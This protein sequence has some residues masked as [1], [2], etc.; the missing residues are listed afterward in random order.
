MLDTVAKV[1]KDRPFSPSGRYVL[2]YRDGKVG[3]TPLPASA[4]SKYVIMR[5]DNDALDKGFTNNEWA[6]IAR[7]IIQIKHPCPC[8]K[9]FNDTA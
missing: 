6:R 8:Q 5:V 7:R 9:G 1:I 4:E 2:Y 3:I